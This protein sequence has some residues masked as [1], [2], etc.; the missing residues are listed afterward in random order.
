MI[1]GACAIV[2]PMTA[3]ATCVAAVQ[4]IAVGGLVL[5]VVTL[6]LLAAHARR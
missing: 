1:A 4:A 5:A 3:T 6:A 2:S